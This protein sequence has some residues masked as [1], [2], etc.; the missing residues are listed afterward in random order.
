MNTQP[1]SSA[2]DADLRL[3]PAAMARAAER[4]REIALRTGTLLIV[5]RNGVIERIRPNTTGAST[6]QEDPATYGDRA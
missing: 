6:V 3:S 2:R 1:I 4:A 5:S